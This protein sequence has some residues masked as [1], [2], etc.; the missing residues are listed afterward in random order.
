MAQEER[1]ISGDAT[2]IAAF[3]L[4]QTLIEKLAEHTV[5]NHQDVQ[6]VVRKSID[7]N[8]QLFQQDRGS[9]NR[10]AAALL[11]LLM[12]RIELGWPHHPISE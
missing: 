12:E 3:T 7:V 6:E 4:L 11:S 8:L 2:S 5:L 9:L 10:E 1:P